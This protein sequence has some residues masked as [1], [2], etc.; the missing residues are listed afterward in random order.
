[1]VVVLTAGARVGMLN[2]HMEEC[3]MKYV[4]VLLMAGLLAAST[5]GCACLCSKKGGCN[6]PAAETG[7]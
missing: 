5:M 7:K 3:L 4:L 2:P 1:M 6:A